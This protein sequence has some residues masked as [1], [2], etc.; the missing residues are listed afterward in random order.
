MLR[1]LIESPINVPE[2]GYIVQQC[3]QHGDIALERRMIR[4]QLLP[5]RIHAQIEKPLYF[6][7]TTHSIAF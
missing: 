3:V 6:R 1:K 2:I 7:I 4:F 5:D